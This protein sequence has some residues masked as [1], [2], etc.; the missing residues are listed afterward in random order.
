M[1]E[2]MEIMEKTEKLCGM[3]KKLVDALDAELDKGICNV[4]TKEAGDVVDMIKDLAEA[5]E[6]YWKAYYYKTVVC[7]MLAVENEGMT[8]MPDMPESWMLPNNRAGYDNWRYASGRYAPKGHG[9]YSG[10]SGRRGFR[11]M[12][13]VMYPDGENMPWDETDMEKWTGRYGYTD[14]DMQSIMRD[15]KH[16]KAYKNWK[17]SRR[18]YTETHSEGDKHEMS[19]HAKE[20]MA[21]TVMTIKEIWVDADPDLREKMKKDIMALMAEMK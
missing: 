18:H 16:G 6:K 4:D 10:H 11:P 19:E 1:H 13:P 9:H 7:Q 15:E 17:M 21:D 12:D 2:I 14:P 20:H 8:E 5:E 3:N